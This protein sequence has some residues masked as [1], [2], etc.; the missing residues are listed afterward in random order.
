MSRFPWRRLEKGLF[1]AVM[2]ALI[3]LVAPVL[4]GPHYIEYRF[5]PARPSLTLVQLE[6]QTGAT[7]QTYR[8]NHQGREFTYALGPLLAWAAPSGPPIYVF[9]E[10][11][12][13]LDYTLDAGDDQRFGNDWIAGSNLEELRAQARQRH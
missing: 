2:L 13:L 7:L 6:R 1:F 8:V 5:K 10:A 3:L 4:I 12:R 9:D 11:G